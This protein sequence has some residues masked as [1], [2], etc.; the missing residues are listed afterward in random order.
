MHLADRVSIMV[1]P[2]EPVLNQVKSICEIVSAQRG[3]EFLPE[4][5]DAFLRISEAE[6]IWMDVLYHPSF[7]MI[8]T[9]EIQWLSLE[10]AAELTR[11]MSRIIDYRSAFTAMHSA[12]VSASAKKLAQLSGMTEEEVLMMEIAGNLHDVGKLKVPKAIL[13]KPGKL[14]EAEFNII[15]EHTYYTRL[16]LMG[17]DG[18]EKVADW[19]GF[20][21]EKLNG[22]GYPF[23]MRAEELD[24]G[25]R[26]MSVADIF[27]AIA[28]VRPYRKGM[29]REQIEDIMR[30]NVHSGA[31]CGEIVGLLLDNYEEVDFARDQRS[32]Q[33]GERYFQSLERE[34]PEESV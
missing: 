30:Q 18:F 26:I 15:K 25:S 8:F 11:L 19:A 3:K 33:E 5:V 20:H 10:R 17:V 22:K 24:L 23:H 32:R 6:Y 27:S 31:I 12:G 21:H 29:R 16:I 14:T 9:G 7:L 2:S 4:A 1:N 13:E 34:T 28:E